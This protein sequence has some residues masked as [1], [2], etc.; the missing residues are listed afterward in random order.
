METLHLIHTERLHVFEQLQIEEAVLRGSNINLCLINEGSPR[1]I[2]MGISGKPEQL[3]DLHKVA[4]DQIPVIQRFSGGGTVVVDENTLFI[5]FIFAKSSLPIHPFPEPILRWSGDL[6]TQS[7]QIPGFHLVEN[8]YAIG[9]LKCGGN[10]QYIQKDRWLHHTTFL[11]DYSEKNMEYL[12]LPSK[13]PKY[14]A[15]RS[16]D[17]FLCRLKSF[18]TSPQE[19]VNQLY[20]ELQKRF[21]CRLITVQD[22][23]WGPHRQAVRW[24]DL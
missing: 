6:Y 2:V 9:P 10:A 13:Q 12:L 23:K 24:I 5:T 16:H 19:L 7:W 20:T 1:A 18:A 11:W 8:D 17:E 21:D 22:L 15:N 14:R 3:L 4:Q